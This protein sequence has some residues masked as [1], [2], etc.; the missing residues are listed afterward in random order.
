M[1]LNSRQIAT[2]VIN[3]PPAVSRN[4]LWSNKQYGQNKLEALYSSFS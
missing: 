2:A 1:D 3:M 4:G